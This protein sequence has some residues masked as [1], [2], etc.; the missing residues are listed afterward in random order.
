MPAASPGTTVSAG[1]ATVPG[2]KIYQFSGGA[3]SWF[4][5]QILG[6]LITICT[7]GTCYPFAV[8]LVERRR[9]K[10]TYRQLL[11]IGT[12]WGIFGLW[13]KWLLLS[14]I[15]VGIYAFWVYPRLMQW[16]VENTVYA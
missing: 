16:K 10:N 2:V 5:T 13:I 7:I 1:A 4:G 12:G 11:F 8:V 3:A 14:I 6:V 9:A 15:T